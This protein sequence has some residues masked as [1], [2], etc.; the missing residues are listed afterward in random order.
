M[1][2][3]VALLK[4]S[5]SPLAM[6]LY[7]SLLVLKVTAGQQITSTGGIKQA[8]ETDASIDAMRQ[9][10]A[11]DALGVSGLPVFPFGDRVSLGLLE[12]FWTRERSFPRPGL[13]LPFF[14]KSLG[15]GLTGIAARGDLDCF[16]SWLNRHSLPLVHRPCFQ[17]LQTC[18][19]LFLH[20]LSL[21]G[22]LPLSDEG[23]GFGPNSYQW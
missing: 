7:T 10:A 2:F 1:Y 9:T 22:D 5:K 18:F 20:V 19:F 8:L 4:G 6:T 11:G 21:D 3:L 23:L 13:L 16:P 15:E 14:F 17:N 12:P